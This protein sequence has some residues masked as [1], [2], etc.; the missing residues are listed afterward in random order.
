MPPLSEYVTVL[1]TAGTQIAVST[2]LAAPT[3][4]WEPGRY[5]LVPSLQPDNEEP[6]FEIPA[7]VATINRVPDATGACKGVIPTPVFN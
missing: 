1:A 6:I 2:T 4:Y 5:V 3:V 7:L